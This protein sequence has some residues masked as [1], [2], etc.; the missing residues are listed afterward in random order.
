[1][2]SG[3]GTSELASPNVEESPLSNSEA[4]PSSNLDPRLLGEWLIDDGATYTITANDGDYELAIVDFDGEVLEV[5]SVTWDEGVLAWTYFVPSTDTRVNE[6]TVSISENR[7]DVQW[8]NSEGNT[9]VDTF[10]RVK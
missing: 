4:S 1:M 3:C 5:E 9:G 8:E 2:A 6:E 10:N 7:L